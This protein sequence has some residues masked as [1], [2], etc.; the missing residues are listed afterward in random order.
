M[1]WMMEGQVRALAD[2]L[3]VVV[4]HKPGWV[5]EQELVVGDEVK[6]AAF[7]ERKS[8]LVAIVAGMET[9]VGDKLVSISFVGKD[10]LRPEAKERIGRMVIGDLKTA[11]EYGTVPF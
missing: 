6:V 9:L 8:R 3:A 1:I 4:R 7:G 11:D 5:S 2:G 10:N